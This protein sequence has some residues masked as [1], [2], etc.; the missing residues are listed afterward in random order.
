MLDDG[1][2]AIARSP[3]GTSKRTKVWDPIVR[4]FHWTLVTGIVANLTFLREVKSVH[5]Y[6]G[7]VIV[8]AIAVRLIWG[9]I[10]S[11]HARF[12]DF[13]TGPRRLVSYM[14]AMFQRRE[15]RYI[16]HNPA[17]GLMMIALVMLSL[18]CGVTGWM[19]GLDAFW[20]APWLEATHEVA[21]NTIMALAILHVLA[22]LVESW[23]HRENLILSMVT[24]SKRA[25]IGT[26]V[27]H[28]P[29]TR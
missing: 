9:F 14:A 28:A 27:D 21:A 7:Y 12:T 18:F 17:G 1:E 10:G 6:V 29:P 5:R 15:P 26:D 16:G 23:R 4:L 22:A 25:A 13:V 8:A 3:I 11:R 24:G 2:R 20:G 19:M